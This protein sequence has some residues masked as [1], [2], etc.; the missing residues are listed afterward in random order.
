M[1]ERICMICQQPCGIGG[2]GLLCEGC[3]GAPIRQ[4]EGAMSLSVATQ[5]VVPGENGHRRITVAH[6]AVQ[7]SRVT[8]YR[9]DGSVEMV[10]HPGRR[11]IL[12]PSLGG[13]AFGGTMGGR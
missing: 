13:G 3:W 12:P 1:A 10:K 5:T 8:R 4:P 2:F 6:A 7:D 11:T 9:S